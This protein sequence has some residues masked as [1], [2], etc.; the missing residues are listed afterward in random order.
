[1]RFRAVP[2]A[3]IA[4]LLLAGCGYV[5][6]GR[7]PSEVTPIGD[8]AIAQAYSN[9]G[10]ENKILKQ[11]VALAR[12]EQDALRAA[13]DQASGG[14]SPDLVARLND[15]T[16]ELATLRASSAKLQAQHTAP[17]TSPPAQPLIVPA[18]PDEALAA[19]QRD[20]VQLKDENVRLR[21]ELEQTHGVNAGLTEQLKRAAAAS[22]E[23]Q[24]ALTQLNQELLAQKQARARAEQATE[25]A[26]AQLR[27]VTAEQT[28]PTPAAALT[29]TGSISLEHAKSPPAGASVE[30]HSNLDGPRPIPA[31]PVR[32]H[33]VEPGDTL[34]KLSVR[35]Y[36]VP[37]RWRAI[38][39]ANASLLGNGQPLTAGM[40]LTIP[41]R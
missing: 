39:D 32:T 5:H 16:R 29:A 28:H 11:E 24:T 14:G 17:V 19:A 9:L 26:F 3:A 27:A 4:V 33:V 40:E 6:F 37:D 18:A 12:K 34:E 13:L 30:L 41:A 36:G 22:E 23:A 8:A 2:L 38:I 31:T 20:V 15:A 35:Y 1:M 10:T 25:A 7:L 21:T